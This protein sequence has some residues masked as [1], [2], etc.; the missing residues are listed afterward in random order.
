MPRR[1][2]KGLKSLLSSELDFETKGFDIAGSPCIGMRFKMGA[3]QLL[4]LKAKKGY[5]ACS[6]IDLSRAEE[7]GD[8]AAIIPG[9]SSFDQLLAGKVAKITQKAEKL[10]VRQGMGGREALE[11]LNH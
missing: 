6:Y 10:G 4:V 2:P 7:F 3:R 8:A 5:I 11:V 1:L 9:A